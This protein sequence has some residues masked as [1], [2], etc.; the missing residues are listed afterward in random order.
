VLSPFPR[1]AHFVA[2]ALALAAAS[3]CGWLEPALQVHVS[4]DPAVRATC[5]RVAVFTSSD[6]TGEA[7]GEAKVERPTGKD[8]VFVAIYKGALPSQV[9]VTARPMFGAGCSDPLVFNGAGAV[10]SATFPPS[11]VTTVDLALD[12]PVAGDADGDGFVALPDGPDCDDGAAAVYPGAPEHCSEPADYNCDQ[13]I[14]CADPTCS[15]TGCLAV[16][17][18]LAFASSPLTLTAGT[19]SAAPVLVDTTGPGGVMPVVVPTTV[20]F[21]ALDGN[22]NVFS[23]ACSTPATAITIPAGQSRAQVWVSGTVAGPARLSA[24]APGLGTVQQSE[25]VQPG[26][27]N[28]LAFTTP[29]QTAVPLNGCSEPVT[30]QLRDAFANPTSAGTPLFLAL[31]S[32]A[33]P[34]TTFKFYPDAACLNPA[35][36]QTP[37][38]LGA[39]TS[40]FYFKSTATSAGTVTI[41]ATTQGKT[42]TQSVGLVART[43]TQL[44]FPNAPVTAGQNLCSPAVTLQT[45]DATGQPAPVLANL[46]IP[47][48]ATGVTLTFFRDAACA[49][50]ATSA[51]LTTGLSSTVF[52]FKGPQGTPTITA[53]GG[54]LGSPMQTETISPSAATQLAFATAAQTTVVAGACS[55]PVEIEARDTSGAATAVA[56]ATTVNLATSPAGRLSLY[57]TANCSGGPITAATMTAGTSKVTIRFRGTLAGSTDIQASTTGNVLAAATQTEGVVAAA[58]YK[59]AIVAG[60]GQTLLT[61]TCGALTLEQQDQYGNPATGVPQTMNLFS[62]PTTGMTFYAN[63]SCTGGPVVTATIPAGS[64]QAS[65][66]FRS[67]TAGSYTLSEDPASA[68]LGDAVPETIVPTATASEL[69]FTSTAQ[70]NVLAGMC[71]AAVRL[72]AYNAGGMVAVVGAATTV[73]LGAAG[74]AGSGVAFYTSS[75]CSGGSVPSVTLP[76]GNSRVTYYFKGT[77][78]GAGTLTASAGGLTAPTPQSF[79]IAPGPPIKLGITK[80]PVTVTAGSCSGDPAPIA[81]EVQ[82]TFGNPSPVSSTINVAISGANGVPADTIR[83]SFNHNCNGSPL[84][85]FQIF[86]GTSASPDIF[87]QTDTAG[88]WTVSASSPPLTQDDE[89]ETVNPDSPAQLVYTSAAQTVIRGMCSP[90]PVT[91]QLQDNF[92]NPAP[93]AGSTNISLAPGGFHTNATCT[94][95]IGT[96]VLVVPAGMTTGQFWFQA[97][98]ATGSYTITISGVGSPVNQ[99]ETIQ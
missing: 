20:T 14:G 21:S 31:T 87:F 36:T 29:A 8:E 95:A 45:Q 98:G 75:T 38:A 93:A 60:G 11:G 77:L 48:S 97:P 82:D 44:V 70:S 23:D 80:G 50:P 5:V 69:R 13:K 22:L 84:T 99:A 67:T 32:D 39:T 3:G 65:V 76:S 56:T 7:A 28:A 96:N 57:A 42:A 27:V 34:G 64:L 26:A 16:P 30:V 47:L 12:P 66:Y 2:A 40:T 63:S 55:G 25:T 79:S 85:A 72:T 17:T 43:A 71:S 74:A 49:T 18:Q 33:N 92:G 91:F 62:S 9:F 37:V 6:V 10:T 83:F 4:V 35:I 86:A 46:T 78:A 89:V 52:Y 81:V 54:A 51:L 61:N 53:D 88:A 94:S 68:V 59:V 15:A 58:P 24:T 19:C 1:F 90:A 73:T 41:T